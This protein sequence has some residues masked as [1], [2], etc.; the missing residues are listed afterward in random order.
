MTDRLTRAKNKKK[1]SRIQKNAKNMRTLEGVTKETIRRG[2]HKGLHVSSHESRI[3]LR[4]IKSPTP[5]A[6]V[7]ARKILIG[8]PMRYCIET[9]EKQDQTKFN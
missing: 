8:K 9:N 2:S 7:K 6:V 3:E 1:E 5:E 4:N